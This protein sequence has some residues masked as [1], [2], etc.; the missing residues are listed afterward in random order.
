MFKVLI[1]DD[2]EVVCLFL[3][4]LLTN[5]FECNVITA[6]NGLEGLSIIEKES[7]DIVFLDITMPVMDGIETLELVRKDPKFKT[8]P[9]IMLTALKDKQTVSNVMNL[10]VMAY[11][12]K[13]LQYN[14]AYEKIKE[15][16][17]QIKRDKE[18]AAAVKQSTE[19][20]L[21]KILVVDPDEEF[22]GIIKKKLE[23]AFLIF[24]SV[25]GAEGLKLFMQELPN[26]VFLGENL[27]LLN[28]KR[29]AQKIKDIKAASQNKNYDVSIFLIKESPDITAEEN[30]LFNG[31][32]QK[33]KNIGLFLK[34]LGDIIKETTKI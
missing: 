17:E 10:G 28:E 1:I 4:R 29:L 26:I 9:V 12:L 5:K 3:G 30:E 22:R 33:S 15:I 32:L 6:E 34:Q 23:K 27:P 8:L 21:Q 2:D 16:F 13:P 18:K 25:S 20:T 31:V 19:S 14:S 7:P 11:L 24:E